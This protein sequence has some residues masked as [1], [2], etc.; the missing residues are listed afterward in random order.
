MASPTAAEIRLRLGLRNT[1][2]FEKIGQYDCR[3]LPSLMPEKPLSRTI[4]SND[5]TVPAIH[6][7]YCVLRCLKNFVHRVG[8]G[9]TG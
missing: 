2:F 9:R 3:P 5:S 7:A 6:E 1:V 4:G 8:R